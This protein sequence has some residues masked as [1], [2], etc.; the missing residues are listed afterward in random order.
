MR[1]PYNRNLLHV[2]ECVLEAFVWIFIWELVVAYKRKHK[3]LFYLFLAL[4]SSA[5]LICF[6]DRLS[7]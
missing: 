5:L 6:H 7:N 3:F 1:S 4:A 2:V